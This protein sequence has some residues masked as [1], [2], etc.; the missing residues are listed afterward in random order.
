MRDILI[1]RIKE[2]FGMYENFNLYQQKDQISFTF[3]YEYKSFVGIHT[4]MHASISINI[5]EKRISVSNSNY[6][7]AGDMDSQLIE[8]IYRLMLYVNGDITIE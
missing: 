2:L 7:E 5:V 8:N 3:L 6:H 1:A 4:H